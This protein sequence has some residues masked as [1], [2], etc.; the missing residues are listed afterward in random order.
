MSHSGSNGAES[1]A[2]VFD[3]F[4]YSNVCLDRNINGYKTGSRWSTSENSNAIY[5]EITIMLSRKKEKT[6][7]IWYGLLQKHS[8]SIDDKNLFHKGMECAFPII[9]S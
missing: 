2:T 5:I 7:F 4:S 9:I 6:P 8:F 1:L 3:T